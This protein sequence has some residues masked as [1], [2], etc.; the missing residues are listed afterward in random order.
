MARLIT[1]LDIGT[2]SIKVAVAEI[3]KEEK[4]KLIFLSKQIS[5]GMRKGTVTQFDEVE[6]CVSS[7]LLKVKG[8]AKGA[9]KNIFLNVGGIKSRTQVSK[10]VVVVSRADSEIYQDDIDR[11]IKTSKDSIASHNRTIIHAITRSFIVDG[12]PNIEDPIGLSGNRL[13]VESYIIDYLAQDLRSLGKVAD[14]VGGVVG[15]LVYNPVATSRSVLNKNQ[16]DLGV[17]MIDIG[18]GTTGV[19]VFEEGKM[20]HSAVLPV[21]SANITN[22]LAIGLKIPIE[23][24]EAMKLSSG[25]AVSKDISIKEKLDLKKFDV[26]SSGMVTKK[27]FSEII[28]VRLAEIFELVNNELKAIGKE[29][30]LPAGVILSGG[31]SK[32]PGIVELAKRELRLPVQLGMLAPEAVSFANKEIEEK[33]EDPEYITSLGLVLQGYDDMMEQKPRM[34]N[35]FSRILNYFLP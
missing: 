27:F 22:D 7:A 30:N 11:A 25:Y 13:E 35:A 24:A 19:A 5:A 26:G 28:E 17:V 16:K 14:K 1:G 2:A 21:G 10:G 4:P 8:V 6:K 12:M 29:K 20:L 15:G 3:G 33:V 18:F 31:G 34:G 32:M 9:L 23:A